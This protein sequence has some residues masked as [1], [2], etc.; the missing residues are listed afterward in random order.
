[1]NTIQSSWEQYKNIV[2]PNNA[3]AYQIEETRKAFYAGVEFMIQMSYLMGREDLS[4]EACIAMMQGI[5][6]EFENFLLELDENN[7]IFIHEPKSNRVS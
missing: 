7:K 6:E 4:E 2:I 5:H 1:M 3:S